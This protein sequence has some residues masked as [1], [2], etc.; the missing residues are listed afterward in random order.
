MKKLIIVLF[1]II[2]LA[3]IVHDVQA[4]CAMCKAVT[5]SN[6]DGEANGVG[7]GLNTGI[8]Y[9]M[10]IPYCLLMGLLYLFFKDQ[11]KEKIKRL[12]F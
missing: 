7:K 12:K 8:L 3:I 2:A 5:E 10:A 6:I 4:Q 9:L 11:I 1:V